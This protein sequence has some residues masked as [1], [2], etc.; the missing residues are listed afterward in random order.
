MVITDRLFKS[1]IF[2]SMKNTTIEAVVQALIKC[3]IQHHEFFTAVVS[4]KR[5]QFVSLIWKQICLIMKIS[6]RLFTAFHPETDGSTKRMN[7]ELEAYLRCFVL[8]YQND[9]E[10][11][12]PIVMLAINGR[13]SFVIGFSPFFA[14]HGYNIKLIETKEPL[15]TKGITFIAKKE[16]FISKLKNITEMAQ[17][18]MAAAQEK[19]EIY[20]NTH[21]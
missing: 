17:I 12:L 4:N 21:R 19:Y 16:A 7:Q 2:K 6:R 3:L 11:L 8:Y 13:T 9:W 14:T 5:P 10:Q 1:C 18:M 20:A 15:K